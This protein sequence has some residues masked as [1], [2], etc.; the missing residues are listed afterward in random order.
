MLAIAPAISANPLKRWSGISALSGRMDERVNGFRI[1]GEGY[2]TNSPCVC[3]KQMKTPSQNTK[4][5]KDARAMRTRDRLGDALIELMHEKP[6]EEITVQHVLDRAR[7]S[8]S[9]FYSHYTS[10]NDLFFG[11]VDDFWQLMSTSLARSNAK[12][13]RVA[14][15]RELFE[16]IASVGD[17]RQALQA[18]GKMQ[19]VMELGREHFARSIERRLLELGAATAPQSAIL[20]RML[21]GALFSL[22]DYWISH[23]MKETPA[24]IDDLYHETAWRA[25]G[26]L[27]GLVQ[28]S[29]VR[30]SPQRT[31]RVTEE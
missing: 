28:D 27:P 2:R 19:D 9:T 12:S 24:E 7:V 23:R 3:G 8:R 22:L 30:L 6:F 15:V 31:R 29:K 13:N 21:A 14:P 10:K 20:G 16:H 5:K 11:D 18:S 25:V 26:K 17:F 4:R 1:G